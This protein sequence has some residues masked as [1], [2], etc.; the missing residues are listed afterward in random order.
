M[1]R[2]EP[3]NITNRA[4][5]GRKAM[6]STHSSL[7]YHVIFSTKDRLPLITTGLRP[8]LHA[9]LGG[10]VKGLNGTPLA[11]GGVEDHV[12]LLVGL[13]TSHRID[14][15]VRDLKAESSEWC[16]KK[17]ER[18]LFAWQKGYA[19]F[20]ISPSS[21]GAVSRNTLRSWARV[22]LRTTNDLYGELLARFSTR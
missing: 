16:H 2:L 12:H 20:S 11:I 19:V 13:N 21:I 14:Y 3:I 6:P 5:K 15:F 10:I 4:L 18:K 7:H 1:K 17:M 22:V 8:R 9:Y